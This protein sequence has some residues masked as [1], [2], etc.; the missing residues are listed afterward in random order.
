M[1]SISAWLRE[2]I[3]TEIG[4]TITNE[5]GAKRI[6][7]LNDMFRGWRDMNVGQLQEVMTTAHFS[8]YF[9]DA[10]SRMFYKRYQFRGGAWRDYTYPDQAPDFR[11]VSRFR[12]SEPGT[13]TP[14][15]EKGSHKQTSVAPTLVQLG[16]EEFSR[17]FDVSWKAILN[18]DLGAIRETPMAMVS[19]ARRFED[20]FVSDL[21]D[22]ATT[23][24]ALVALGALFAGT[25]RL[26]SAN[27]AIGINA[28]RTRTDAKGNKLTIEGIWL[29]IPPELEIQAATILESAQLAGTANNDTN[30]L[31][32]FI[33]GVRTDPYIA[34]ASP[35]IPWYLV[36]DP[37][38]IPTITVARLN[39]VAGPAVFK[40]R[41]DIEVISGSAPA[42]LL[43]GD[44]ETGNINYV[45]WDV[46]GG[47]DDAT[48]VG[49]TDYR[50]I[51]Y[52]SGTTA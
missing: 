28:M 32:R 14:R 34:T 30:V 49:V 17:G 42:A 5:E 37:G 29:V 50:G 24:A 9:S 12:M 27:L 22:N 7:A 15:R 39:G 47:W 46:I 3:G 8:S 25:G 48:Y 36:A 31:P 10:L 38:E 52:S 26:T 51:Y 43:M 33:R 4:K 11:D 18:D 1:E 41:D 23:Q 21:Y 6:G 13:L 16:V 40:K 45:V 2:Y 20:S 19:A 35:N 44:F